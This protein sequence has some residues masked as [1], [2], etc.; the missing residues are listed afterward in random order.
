MPRH[1]V[2]RLCEAAWRLAE[3]PYNLLASLAYFAVAPQS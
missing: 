3:T 1:L 2:G